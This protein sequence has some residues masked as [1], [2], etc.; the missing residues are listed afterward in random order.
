[1]MIAPAFFNHSTTLESRVAVVFDCRKRLFDELT[2]ADFLVG[3][4][5]RDFAA[6]S[7]PRPPRQS[8]RALP[9][10]RQRHQPLRSAGGRGIAGNQR[11]N[12]MQRQLRVNLTWSSIVSCKGFHS[13]QQL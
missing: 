10:G 4:K 6:T 7:V 9:S 2:T 11:I 8:F 13:A 12:P 5:L 3:K 1:M